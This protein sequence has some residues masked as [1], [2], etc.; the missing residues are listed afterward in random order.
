MSSESKDVCVQRPRFLL[1]QISN[2]TAVVLRCPFR[3]CFDFILLLSGK[4]VQGFII[5]DFLALQAP[6]EREL[7]AVR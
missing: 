4:H 3:I 7:M 1:T 6:L 2:L 5:T